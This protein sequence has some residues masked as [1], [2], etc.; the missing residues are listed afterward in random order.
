MSKTDSIWAKVDLKSSHEKLYGF[1]RNHLGDLVN[2]FPENFNSI[3][4][5]EGQHFE[6]GSLFLSKYE[7]GHEHKVE[8]WVI[9]AVD[10]VKKYIVYEAVEG[11][12]LKQFK[13]LRVKVEAVNGGSTKGGGG[14]NFTKLSIE[15]E[16]ANEN[17]ASPENYL[18]LLVKI[19]K[20]VDA[21]FSKN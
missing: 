20:G 5:V 14:G 11:E 6:R 2:L 18:E 7:L 9:K 21:Y 4:L 12:A 1:F 13:V 17:V 16:K 8:K 19:A 15:Y 3:Q 10:D